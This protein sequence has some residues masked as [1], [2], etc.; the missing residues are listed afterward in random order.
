MSPV[1]L[2]WVPLVAAQAACF[3]YAPA[4]TRNTPVGKV[5]EVKLTPQGA[6]ALEPQVGVSAQVVAGLLMGDDQTAIEMR[7]LRVR[8]SDGLDLKGSGELLRVPHEH[9][10]TVEERRV[11]KPRTWGATLTAIGVVL[12]SSIRHH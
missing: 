11:S 8:R 3:V 12:W 10:I 9:V 6:Q 1:R 7:F 5:I 2:L 4:E